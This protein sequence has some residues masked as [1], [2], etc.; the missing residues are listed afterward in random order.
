MYYTPVLVPA[1]RVTELLETT[2]ASAKHPAA[3]IE[4]AL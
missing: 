2:K 4:S 1:W 3:F